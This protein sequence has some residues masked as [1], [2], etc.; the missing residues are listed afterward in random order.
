MHKIEDKKHELS[1]KNL[2]VEIKVDKIH[3]EI[4][5]E[6]LKM[7]MKLAEKELTQI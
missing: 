7:Q 1:H 4:K 2:E 6:E 5:S 3:E